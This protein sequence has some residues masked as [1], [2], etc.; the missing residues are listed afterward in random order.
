LGWQ[1][2]RERRVP[3]DFALKNNLK[4]V[5]VPALTLVVG[6]LHIMHFCRQLGLCN[7]S[8]KESFKFN[9]IIGT[10]PIKQKLLA[11]PFPANSSTLNFVFAKLMINV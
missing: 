8:L 11:F 6:I 3:Y 7:C 9:K 5:I 10:I 1:F 4:L 2:E